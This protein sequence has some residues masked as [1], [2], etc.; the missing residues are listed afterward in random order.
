MGRESEHV[1]A[2]YMFVCMCV[3]VYQPQI[4]PVR[5]VGPQPLPLPFPPLLPHAWCLCPWG[6]DIKAICTF[7]QCHRRLGWWDYYAERLI[8]VVSSLWGVEVWEAAVLI[9]C[10][11]AL[12]L[13]GI[14]RCPVCWKA[15]YIGEGMDFRAWHVILLQGRA[16]YNRELGRFHEKSHMA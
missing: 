1:R 4:A 11:H 13:L 12:L 7:H 10:W 8:T 9:T 2:Q 14:L 5:P 16:K 15:L 6:G 3:S